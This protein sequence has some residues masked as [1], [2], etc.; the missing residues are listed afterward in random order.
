M[1]NNPEQKKKELTAVWEVRKTSCLV[2][3]TAE[4]PVDIQWN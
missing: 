2:A 1:E 4:K 3:L